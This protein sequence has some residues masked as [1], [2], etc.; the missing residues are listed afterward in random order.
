MT[1]IEIIKK[2]RTIRAYK[3]AS[4]DDK[5]LD[6]IIEAGRLAPSWGNTQT[7]RFIVVKD[8]KIKT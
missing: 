7:W 6:A 5:T 1:V 4:V 2:R 3:S 8:N